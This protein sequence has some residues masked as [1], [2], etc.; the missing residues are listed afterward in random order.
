MI[1]VV[2]VPAAPLL[3]PAVNP[4]A[5]P[6]VLDVR[7]AMRM[8]AAPLADC[9]RVVAVCAYA[10][11][12]PDREI[13][14]P[15][16]QEWPSELTSESPSE[17][18]GEPDPTAA[19]AAAAL[20]PSSVQVARWVLAEVGV[21]A[22]TVVS[23]CGPMAG[24]VDAA[25][26]VALAPDDGLLVVGDGSAGRHEKAPGHIREGAH[27]F[28]AEV[29]RALAGGNPDGLLALDPQQAEHVLAGGLPAWQAAALIVAGLEVTE[30]KVLLTADPHHV[31][32][33]VATWRV[34][35]N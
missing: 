35:R 5:T 23:V 17:F 24:F 34:G 7:T 6:G 27:E 20:E 19:Q 21:S 30:A 16:W 12:Q 15:P 3:L 22:S 11:Q 1:P 33:F 14:V 26:S 4:T 25:R 29:A 31:A 9:A 2:F 10:D 32:Y 8:A 13:P 18:P 28:D